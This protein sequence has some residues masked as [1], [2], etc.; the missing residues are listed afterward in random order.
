MTGNLFIF[1]SFIDQS[2]INFLSDLFNRFLTSRTLG[3]LVGFNNRVLGDLPTNQIINKQVILD[4]IYNS[5]KT[6]FALT[7]STFRIMAGYKSVI[8]PARWYK[9]ELVNYGDI[10]L[11][12]RVLDKHNIYVEGKVTE[13]DRAKQHTNKVELQEC[14]KRI[15]NVENNKELQKLSKQLLK[16]C[17]KI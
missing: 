15:I 16:E 11:V 9:D 13:E 10:N 6:K 14:L 2:N 1:A 3:L 4:G 12:Y 7:E 17:K 8:K 5:I